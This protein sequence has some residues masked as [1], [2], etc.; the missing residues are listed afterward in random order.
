MTDKLREAFTDAALAWLDK[1]PNANADLLDESMA[2]RQTYL[3]LK[4]NK[5]NP[6]TPTAD[7]PEGTL[8]YVWQETT[9]E[10]PNIRRFKGMSDSEDYP[11]RMDC[12]KWKHAEILTGFFGIPNTGVCPWDD[13]L[14]VAVQFSRGEIRVSKNISTLNWKLTVNSGNPIISSFEVKGQE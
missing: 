4:R 1:S 14:M 11:F 6:V 2:M 9:G 12:G 7:T 3:A 8:C 5:L 13:S 10:I